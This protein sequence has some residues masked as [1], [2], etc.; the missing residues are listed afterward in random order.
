GARLLGET[1]GESL[2]I[3]LELE[4]G[5]RGQGSISLVRRYVAIDRALLE[6]GPDWVCADEVAWDPAESRVVAARVERWRDLVL[7]RAPV[8]LRDRVAAAA[9]LRTRADGG[10]ATALG[11][12]ADDDEVL[13]A[14]LTLF[15]QLEPHHRLPT[16]ALPADRAGWLRCALPVMVTGC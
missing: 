16:G 14:R 4:A 6:A 1:H 12:L 13:L 5:P 3:A 11:T 7:T 15:A 10:P 2:L 9:V 8:P